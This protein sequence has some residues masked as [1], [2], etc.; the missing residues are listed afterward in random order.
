MERRIGPSGP[1]RRSSLGS[2]DLAQGFFRRQ[3]NGD[4]VETEGDAAGAAACVGERV[5][6]RHQSAGGLFNP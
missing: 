3:G 4:A 6:G 5:E 1:G 2:D